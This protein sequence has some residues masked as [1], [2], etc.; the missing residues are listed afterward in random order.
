MRSNLMAGNDIR[1]MTPETVEILTNKKMIVI[2]Q[3]PL[4]VQT[5][6]CSSVDGPETWFKPVANG[7]WANNISKSCRRTA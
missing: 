3:N 4:G 6:K 7:E 2:N 1:D 5:W